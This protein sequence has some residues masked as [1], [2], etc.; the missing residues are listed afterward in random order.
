VKRFSSIRLAVFFILAVCILAGGWAVGQNVRPKL[1]LRHPVKPA[2]ANVQPHAA[3][4][5]KPLPDAPSAQ[6]LRQASRGNNFV[7]VAHPAWSKAD[8]PLI[9]SS[10]SISVIEEPETRLAPE[11]HLAVELPEAPSTLHQPLRPRREPEVFLTR[12]FDPSALTQTRRYQ[13]SSSVTLMGRATDAA[14]RLFITRDE[15]GNRRLNTPYLL[16]ALTVVAAVNAS[17]RYRA[18]SGAAPLSDFGST[19]GSDA[20]L[21]LLHEFG[22][23]LRQAVSDHIPTFMFRMQ[24]HVIRQQASRTMPASKPTR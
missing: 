10:A 17:R 20:G 19:L 21:N 2:V 5:S 22:P 18:R 8:V 9:S 15:F 1:A 16:R 11:T 23:G 6:V 12:Y 3:S 4:L 24:E 13:P 7:A 14:S